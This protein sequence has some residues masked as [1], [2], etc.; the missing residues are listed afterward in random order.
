VKDQ[1][2]LAKLQ[3]NVEWWQEGINTVECNKQMEVAGE[4]RPLHS[5]SNLSIGCADF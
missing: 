5:S 3:Q 1:D 2:V 4:V